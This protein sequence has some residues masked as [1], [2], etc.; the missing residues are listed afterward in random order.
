LRSGKKI[1]YLA[2]YEPNIGGVDREQAEVF[3]GITESLR[4]RLRE[5]MQESE[6]GPLPSQ[7]R[8]TS[9]SLSPH[10]DPSSSPGPSREI[11]LDAALQALA[12]DTT[13]EGDIQPYASGQWRVAGRQISAAARL[14]DRLD[15]QK[16]ALFSSIGRQYGLGDNTKGYMGGEYSF[17]LQKRRSGSAVD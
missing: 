7:P 14:Q 3:V 4:N 12:G 15:W 6:L 10:L 11:D 13:D 9:L 17:W 8:A 16:G 5:S 1:V 2:V